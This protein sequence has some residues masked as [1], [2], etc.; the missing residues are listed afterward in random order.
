MPE[1]KTT[2]K[3]DAPET[4]KDLYEGETAAKGGKKTAKKAPAGRVFTESY[5]VLVRPLVTEKAAHASA[6]GKYTFVVDANANK[7]MVARSI[8]AVYGVK[9]TDVRIVRLPGKSV[10]RGNV[11]GLRAG[12]KKA[13]ISLPKGATIQIYEGV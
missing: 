7:I 11:R 12:I 2:T 13:I 5:R 6:S 10:R 3:T 4:M 9:P 1:K 8:E